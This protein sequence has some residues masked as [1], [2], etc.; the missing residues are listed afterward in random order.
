[1]IEK[2]KTMADEENLYLVNSINPWRLEGQKTIIFELLEQLNWQV[3]DYIVVPAGNL[4]NTSA[5]GKALHEA[6]ELQRLLSRVWKETLKWSGWLRAS[7]G[8]HP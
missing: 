1:M 2:A 8:S 4:G 3:P 5:F 7:P 6:K